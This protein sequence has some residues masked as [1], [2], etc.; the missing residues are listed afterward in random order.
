MKASSYQSPLKI[1]INNFIDK[2]E[3]QYIWQY[4]E[5]INERDALYASLVNKFGSEDAFIQ[6][7]QK[8]YNKRIADAVTNENE[9]KDFNIQDGEMVRVKDA[10]F[11]TP[12]SNNGRAHF[13]APV[14]RISKLTMGT[15]WFNL[16]VIWL[17][18]SV[19]FVILYFDILRKI[20]AYFE[21]VLLSR[22]NRI[23]ILRLLKVYEQSE[24]RKVSK[25]IFYTRAQSHDEKA[26]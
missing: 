9:I 16:I 8:F 6:F 4:N 20:L 24:T 1:I 18:S 21:S 7:K 5:A 26:S 10:I 25:N 13:Y 23:R 2:A 15:F 12:E 14:K 22:R 19:L 11:R 3:K 17:F